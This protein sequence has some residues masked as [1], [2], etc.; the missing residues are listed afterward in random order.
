MVD[1]DEQPRPRPVWPWIAA[2]VALAVIAP[3]LA[4][5]LREE[6]T[7]GDGRDAGA[8][9]VSTPSP[10]PATVPSA[11][12]TTDPT[13]DP[14][15]TRSAA[16][17]K[18]RALFFGDSYFIGGGYTDETNSMAR[19]A[20]NRLGWASEINGGGGTGF[21]QTNYEYDLGNYLDQIDAGAFDVG[22]RRWVVIEGGNNDLGVPLDEVR[23]NARKVVRVAQRTFPR[24]KVVLVGP[25]DTD[26]DHSDLIPMIKLMRGVAARREIP[27]INQKAWLAGHYDLIGPDYVHPYPEGHRILGRKLARALRALGA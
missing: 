11:A 9:A 24:A 12:P 20:S 3:L 18:T 15:I 21:V 23:V 2:L 17:G 14:A 8:P 6:P 26:A 19:L 1:P 22:R 5:L 4:L 16:R 25:L 10:T 27:F 13:T 7:S